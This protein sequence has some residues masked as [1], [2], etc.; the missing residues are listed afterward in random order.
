MI[1]LLYVSRFDKETSS[2]GLYAES[3][4]QALGRT[5]KVQIIRGPITTGDALALDR[6]GPG[7]LGS[8]LRKLAL[9]EN[10][11]LVHFHYEPGLYSPRAVLSMV[12]TAARLPP[13]IYTLHRVAAYDGR[14]RASGIRQFRAV[15]QEWL[16][17]P[18]ARLFLVHAEHSAAIIRDRY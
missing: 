9:D 6:N 8:N 18:R 1:R 3:L 11:D 17:A 10:A 15:A 14:W 2:D 12:R 5:G 7:G 4:T 13:T 16:L